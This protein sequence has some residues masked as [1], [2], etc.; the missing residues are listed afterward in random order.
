MTEL[1]VS[2][3]LAAHLRRDFDRSFAA[4][5]V[6]SEGRFEDLLAIRVGSDPY[7]VRLRE[8]AG[9]FVDR[10][11]V[12]VPGPVAELVGV[13]GFRGTLVPVY[14]LRALLG[15]PSHEPCR[16]MLLTAA[17]PLRDGSTNAVALAFDHFERHL[18]LPASTIA[19]RNAKG[20]TRQGNDIVHAEGI[21]RPLV[22]LPSLLEGIAQ[23]AQE[24]NLQQEP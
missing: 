22:D 16:W 1:E 14:D 21:A 2:A 19:G 3:G 13:A 11:T 6:E 12:P 10:T 5:P 20:R 17:K 7:A 24:A 9:L 8:V 23:R 15:H 4:A 18:R